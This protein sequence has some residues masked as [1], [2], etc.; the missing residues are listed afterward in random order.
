MELLKQVRA[1]LSFL[2][3][4]GG[5][6][7]DVSIPDIP[8]EWSVFLDTKDLWIGFDFPDSENTT[9]CIYIGKKDSFFKAHRHPN[10]AEHITILNK[11]GK[12][13]VFTET[14]SKEYSFPD[15]V[16]FKEGEAHRVE[17]LEETKIICMWHPKMEHGWEGEFINEI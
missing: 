10:N 12:I 8:K 6:V 1:K 7:Y 14:Y 3:K 15:S 5:T 13:K 4:S 2:I 17:F 11:V 9:A 16:F